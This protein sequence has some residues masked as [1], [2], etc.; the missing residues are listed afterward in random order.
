MSQIIAIDVGRNEV[1]GFNGSKEVVLKS[2]V[3]SH[4]ILDV[5]PKYDDYEVE[6]NGVKKFV[7]NLAIVESK[8]KSNRATRTKIHNDT[9]ILLLTALSLLVDSKKPFNVIT[10]MPLD[11]Y[12]VKSKNE[13]MEYLAGKHTVTV[14]GNTAEFEI[15]KKNFSMGQ[16]AVGSYW[17]E[18]LDLKGNEVDPY[19]FLTKKVRVIDIGS[20]T[21]NFCTI[22]KGDY[23]NAESG[24]LNFGT[25]RITRNAPSSEEEYNELKSSFVDQIVADISQEWEDYENDVVLI[26]GA[27]SL[28]L[29][30]WLIKAY[31]NAIMSSNPK[32]GNVYGF[33]KIEVAESK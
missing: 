15:T 9:K 30:V 26:T 2:V 14:N 24:C 21:I 27:G 20:R 25:V 23:I 1:K 8:N 32:M 17:N 12:S 28:L 16:E 31:L 4:H 5:K 13:I 7:S 18:V 11:Q 29:Q 22:D 10:G 19:K 6:I 33:Y 3:G